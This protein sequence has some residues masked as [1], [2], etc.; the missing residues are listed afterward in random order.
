MKWSTGAPDTL[1]VRARSA[2][3]RGSL[4][5][6]RDISYHDTTLEALVSAVAARNNLKPAVAEPFRGVKV[7]HI[8]QT[9]ET[10][11]KFITRLA[12]LNGAVV[13]IK[14]GSLLFIKPGAAKTASG[15]PIPLM[16]IIRSDGDGHTFNIA[17]RGA[18]TG[19]S[20]SWLHT[21]DPKPK[22][23][24]VQRKTEM[25][26]LRALQ[27]PKAKRPAR[28]C[29]KRRRLKKGI[30]WRAVMKTCLT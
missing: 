18:Y 7:S 6:R 4:N 17:D 13:A 19:V 14:A 25:Q 1:T 22:K 23:V 10:D 24:K 27:H 5:S 26:Y 9:Q 16:T 3:Y 29:R 30:I 20:A 28:R 2:D 12:E 11:A 15:K 8:D 21:K